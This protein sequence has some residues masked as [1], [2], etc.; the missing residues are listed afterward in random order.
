MW[1]GISLVVWN[2]PENP[3]DLK[4]AIKLVNAS[5]VDLKVCDG[6]SEWGEARHITEDYVKRLRTFGVLVYGWGYNYCDNRQERPNGGGGNPDAEADA[7]AERCKVLDLDGYTADWEIE[8]EGHGSEVEKFC[9]R[10][11]LEMGDGFPFAAEVWADLDGH[12]TY[13]ADIICRYIHVLRGMVYRPIWNMARYFTVWDKF[14]KGPHAP[15]IA[16]TYQGI[17]DNIRSDL[18]LARGLVSGIG[19]WEAKSVVDS[20][21]NVQAI[22]TAGDTAQTPGASQGVKIDDARRRIM[23]AAGDLYNLGNQTE[24][25]AHQYI[26]RMAKGE[27]K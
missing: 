14:W 24:G 27:T 20:N 13:P 12:A 26:V 8:A 10:F 15:V 17:A 5:N 21:P 19:I 3:D 2:A 11:K 9:E 4:T 16:V 23:E 6:D 1:D 18:L 7:A 25:L 22:L